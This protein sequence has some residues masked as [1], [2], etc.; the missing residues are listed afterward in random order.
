MLLGTVSGSATS[1]L[2]KLLEHFFGVDEDAVEEEAAEATL[3]ASMIKSLC[4]EHNQDKVAEASSVPTGAE[5]ELLQDSTPSSSQQTVT[6]GAAKRKSTLKEKKVTPDKYPNKCP[7]E[8]AQLFFPTDSDM[9]H[10][11]GVPARLVGDRIK[12]GGYKG[13][14]PC[15]SGGCKYV[16]QTRGVLCDHIC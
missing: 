7:L 8:E 12:L 15:A 16:A 2:W 3:L 4:E 11:T 13:C 9:M 6:S 5:Q 10:Q 14:Y 1:N